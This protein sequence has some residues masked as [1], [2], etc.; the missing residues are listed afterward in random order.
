MRR[1]YQQFIEKFHQ[2][3][4]RLLMNPEF[5]FVVGVASTLSWTSVQ[6]NPKGHA[7]LQHWKHTAMAVGQ[8]A[9]NFGFKDFLLDSL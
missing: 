7:F 1:D 8:E 5:V 6:V 4:P 9:F 3:N 2:L